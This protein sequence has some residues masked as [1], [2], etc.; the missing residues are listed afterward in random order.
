ME[1]WWRILKIGGLKKI[2]IKNTTARGEKMSLVL[3]KKHNKIEIRNIYNQYIK[4]YPKRAM[5]TFEQ[6]I[7]WCVA[8]LVRIDSK[9]QAKE[10]LETSGIN[11]S[12]VNIPEEDSKEIDKLF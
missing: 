12:D 7:L 8:E 4:K 10:I 2:T 5:H 9:L 11:L 1:L 6:G 3:R